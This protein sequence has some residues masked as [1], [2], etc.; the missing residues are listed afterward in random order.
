[1]NAS[2]VNGKILVKVPGENRYRRLR[3]DE[4]IPVGTT[5]DARFGTIEI[6]SAADLGDKTQTGRFRAGFFKIV[7]K[8]KRRPITELR[9]VGGSFSDCGA[10]SSSGLSGAVA[11][12]AKKKRKKGKGKVRSLFGNADGRFRTRGRRGSA[13]VRGTKWWTEDRCDGTLIRVVKGIVA[14][15]DFT[16]KRTVL[17]RK[18]ESYLAPNPGAVRSR[19]SRN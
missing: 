9:L 13:S 6:L 4:Q 5:V 7:Q 14:V 19:R 8:R 3:E 15:R 18:G 17:V 16:R 12:A 10:A 2:V 1:V 11:D